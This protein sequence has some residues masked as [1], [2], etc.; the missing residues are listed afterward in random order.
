MRNLPVANSFKRIQK[1]SKKKYNSKA[2]FKNRANETQFSYFE[3]K[4]IF[5]STFVRIMTLIPV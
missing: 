1:E 4:G 5:K 2:I 3:I